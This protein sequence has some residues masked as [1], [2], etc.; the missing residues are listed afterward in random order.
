MFPTRINSD[1][2][3]PIV[4]RM[5]GYSAFPSAL[6]QPSSLSTEGVGEVITVC[7]YVPMSRGPSSSKLNY[8]FRMLFVLVEPFVKHVII[9][10]CF[11]FIVNF[12]LNSVM[13][14]GLGRQLSCLKHLQFKQEIWSS[15]SPKPME[16]LDWCSGSLIIPILE[17]GNMESLRKAIH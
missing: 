3:C 11:G 15:D 9:V 6:I 5:S 8:L 13:F 10:Q 17:Y 4:L 16:M 1:F 7:I 12:S 2:L 14:F